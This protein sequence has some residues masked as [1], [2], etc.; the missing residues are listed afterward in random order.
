MRVTEENS[1][2]MVYGKKL[3]SVQNLG[4]YERADLQVPK[5]KLKWVKSGP[6]AVLY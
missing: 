2:G 4:N 5:L 1:R 6:G 3:F